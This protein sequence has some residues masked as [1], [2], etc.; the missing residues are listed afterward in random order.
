MEIFCV[1]VLLSMQDL[2]SDQE[3]RDQTDAPCSGSE[4]S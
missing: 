1:C 2:S 3:L 4:E